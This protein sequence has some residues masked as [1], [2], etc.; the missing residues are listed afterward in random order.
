M[1]VQTGKQD[2]AW[3]SKG[4]EGPLTSKWKLLR[5]GLGSC[6]EGETRQE[7]NNKLD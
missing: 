7:K 2:E 4:A 6:E 5:I 1:S 3:I